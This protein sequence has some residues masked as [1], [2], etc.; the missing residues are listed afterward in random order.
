[1]Q[2]PF[3]TTFSKIPRKTYIATEEPSEIIENFSYEKP[4]ESVYKITGVRGSGKTV[5]LARIEEEYSSEE[6]AE[7]GWI[8][9][10]LSPS[11]DMLRQL[12]AMLFKEPFVEK[13]Y[14]STET[15][16]SVNVVGTGGGIEKARSVWDGMFDIGAEL[17]VMM[18]AAARNGKKILIGIDEVSKTRDMVDF[19]LEFE[20]WLR[21]EYPVYLVCTG[22][23]ENILELSNTKNL[24]FFRRAA[25][26]RTTPLSKVGMAEMY[27]RMIPVELPLAKTMANMTKGYAYA[28]QV[29]GVLYFRKDP[30]ESLRDIE[31]A[32]RSELYA[33]SYEKIWEE[34]S[35][36]DRR[37]VRAIL[38][39]EEYRREEVLAALGSKASSYSVYRDRLLKRGIIT[40]RRGYISLALPYFSDYVKEYCSEDPV[41]G[42]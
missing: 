13:T 16:V 17:D 26:I 36:E 40:A 14:Q 8:V 23:Y 38:D 42:G 37:M 15:S 7:K 39:K 22:L 27:R 1:M 6:N 34:M 12:G 9:Y 30:S 21:A 20:K 11:R 2:N 5:M 4:T 29:L 41:I 18:Q 24:T 33:Y 3:T 19:A 25:T 10:R 31:R 28:F 35:T 32:F